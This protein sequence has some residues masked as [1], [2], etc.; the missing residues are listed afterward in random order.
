VKVL[1]RNPEIDAT[2]PVPRHGEVNDYTARNICKDL[3]IPPP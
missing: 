3:V 2:V 1:R